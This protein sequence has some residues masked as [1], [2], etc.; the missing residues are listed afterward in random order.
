[1]APRLRTSAAHGPEL[2]AQVLLHE[3]NLGLHREDDVAKPSRG[4]AVG[5]DAGENPRAALLIHEAARS[6]DRI[7][8]DTPSA[9]RLAR[10]FGQNLHAPGDSFGDQAERLSSAPPREGRR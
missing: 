4:A 1:M 7:D 5:R 9:V 2:I 3:R 6:V 10:P 8:E